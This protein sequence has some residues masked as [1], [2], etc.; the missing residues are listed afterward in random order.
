[1]STSFGLNLLSGLNVHL[2]HQSV[3][4]TAVLL[5]VGR[6][7]ICGVTRS[8]GPGRSAGLLQNRAHSA[9]CWLGPRPLPELRLQPRRSFRRSLSEASS[10]RFLS[11]VRLTDRLIA[12]CADCGRL[13]RTLVP[14]VSIG[15]LDPALVNAADNKRK[16]VPR[17]AVA[18]AAI[19][20]RISGGMSSFSLPT[21]SVGSRGCRA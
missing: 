12:S 16:S 10:F 7:Y 21:A 18:A 14:A 19:A 1:M 15:S 9:H 3:T 8:V 6:M 5:L 20:T 17:N 11:L 4:G 13:E 2:D